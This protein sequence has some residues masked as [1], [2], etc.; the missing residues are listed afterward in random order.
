MNVAQSRQDI[1]HHESIPVNINKI[2]KSL[3]IDL[4]QGVIPQVVI[5]PS[6]SQV[7]FGQDLAVVKFLGLQ[8]RIFVGFDAFGEFTPA[9]EEPCFMEQ[10]LPGLIKRDPPVF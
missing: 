9:E 4:F 1:E 10:L 6:Q 7:C 5:N 8:F 2:D 3:I